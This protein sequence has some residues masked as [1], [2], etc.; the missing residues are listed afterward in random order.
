MLTI[1]GRIDEARTLAW[2]NEF[3]GVIPRPSR[4]LQP[5]Y[6]VEPVQDGER[7]VVLRRGGDVQ[8][9]SAGYHV[10]AGAH[11]D[12]AAVQV[13]VD[14]LTNEPSGRLYKALVET[15]KASSVYG[16]SRSA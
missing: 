11:P 3:F 7:H 10:P 1:A 4:T 9:T 5:T 8:V 12:F 2:V 13:L 14:V 6:T 16:A 15:G